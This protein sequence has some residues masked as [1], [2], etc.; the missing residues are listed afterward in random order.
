MILVNIKNIQNKNKKWKITEL[1]AVIID[2]ITQF[3]FEKARP[4]TSTPAPVRKD[5][6]AR[7][8]E[9]DRQI[10]KLIDLYQVGSIPINTISDKIDSLVSE[11]NA[12]YNAAIE[13]D[14]QPVSAA[15]LTEFRDRFLRLLDSGSLEEK[16]SCLIQIIDKITVT[17]DTVQ[18]LLK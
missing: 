12:L 8:A 16:R 11:K 4:E 18:V 5:Y 2:Y 13:Q 10:S 3:D 15:Q 14:A 1:D 6:S 17:D 7:I 9:I